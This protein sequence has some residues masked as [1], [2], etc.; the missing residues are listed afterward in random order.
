M[1]H[2]PELQTENQTKHHLP[3][4]QR[5]VAIG[6]AFLAMGAG[7]KTLSDKSG[8]VTVQQPA[9]ELEANIDS[10]FNIV[11]LNSHKHIMRNTAELEEIMQD[12]DADAVM[13]QEVMTKDASRLANRFPTWYVS[14][15]IG[16]RLLQQPESGGY[17]NVIMTRQK[18]TDI[19]SRSIKVNPI[20]DKIRNAAVEVLDNVARAD[21]PIPNFDRLFEERRATLAMTNKV[22]TGN[23][24]L[25]DI[26]IMTTHI[27]GVEPVA[28]QQM[29]VIEEEVTNEIKKGRPLVLCADLNKI[30]SV[31]KPRFEKLGF[32]IPPTKYTIRKSKVVIDYCMYRTEGVLGK[33]EVKT[34]FSDMSDHNRLVARFSASLGR[35]A[36]LQ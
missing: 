11:N 32:T 34:G 2:A 5:P 31:V 9:I 18:P 22:L 15:V 25:K 33:A 19:K 26:R 14:H 29:D 20:T 6:A 36:G 28:S 10:H 1:E 30:P 27:S 7:Y 8:E 23:N 17:G 16:E 13:L 12:A 4:W 21:M 3:G 35:L 24:T